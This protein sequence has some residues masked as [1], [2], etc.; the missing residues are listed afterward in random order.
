[1]RC[2]NLC[3]SNTYLSNITDLYRLEP[4]KVS[5]VDCSSLLI[6]ITVLV[7]Y[8]FELQVAFLYS[9]SVDIPIESFYVVFL[10]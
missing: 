9:I 4:L 3:F 5:K 8:L 7:C 10:F 2:L 6:L 1:M